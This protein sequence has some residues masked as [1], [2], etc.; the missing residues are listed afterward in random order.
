MRAIESQA[1]L[2]RGEYVESERAARESLASTDERIRLGALSALFDALGMQGRYDE[3]SAPFRDLE[4]PA[5]PELLNSWLDCV[6]RATAY[7]A[8]GGDNGVREQ[9]LVLVE[10]AKERLDPIVIGWAE[11]MRFHIAR[12]KGRVSESL[13]HA[14]RAADHF[15]SIGNSRAAIQ[16]LGNLGVLFIEVGQLEDADNCLRDV[17]VKARKTDFKYI[18][19]QSLTALTN[20]LAYRGAFDEARVVG[21]QALAVTSAQNDRRFQGSGEAYFSV[22]EYLAG[23]Y[24]R[25]E[26]FARAAL[27]TWAPMPP[28]RPFAMA[29]LARAL[30]AQGRLAEALPNARDAFAQLESMGIVDDGEATIRLALAECLISAGDQPA[31]QEAVATTAKWLHTRAET[32]D[33]PTM[34]ESF[35]TRIPEHRRI[36]ELAREIERE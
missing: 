32:I 11:S 31:A 21:Q 18:L 36:L 1:R 20:V 19:G 15:E 12:G 5:A 3:I 34:R 6:M 13:A 29:L 10:E 7:L 33:D 9:T 25:A 8:A 14:R 30:L 2:W 24:A 16:T 35:L 27:A 28:C 17:L 26:H 22:T 4:R 23:D